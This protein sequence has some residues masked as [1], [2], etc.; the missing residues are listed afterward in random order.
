VE[1]RITFS[2]RLSAWIQPCPNF[3]LRLEV[4]FLFGA[5]L[6]VFLLTHGEIRTLR[7]AAFPASACSPAVA[8]SRV[9]WASRLSISLSFFRLSLPRYFELGSEFFC[10]KRLELRFC[11]G[12]LSQILEL[13]KLLLFLSGKSTCLCFCGPQRVFRRGSTLLYLQ[14]A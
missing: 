1:T 4:Q 14:C 8:S 6:V 2:R 12:I 9:R 13:G 10:G 3:N 7:A 5:M 11:L